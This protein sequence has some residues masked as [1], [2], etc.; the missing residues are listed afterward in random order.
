MAS[1][2]QSSSSSALGPLVTVLVPVYNGARFLIE[3]LESILAQTHRNLEIIVLDDASTDDTPQ[4]L[5]SYSDR[6]RTIRQRSNKGIYDNVNAGIRAAHGD[7]IAVYHA[8]DIYAPN[9]VQRE[10]AAFESHPEVGAVFCSDI[11][12]DEAGREYGRLQLPPEIR[13]SQPLSF[14]TVFNVLL[15]Y[16]NGFLRCP[17]AM[18]RADVHARVGLY[19]QDLFRN[20]SDL[21]MWIRIAAAHPI[22]VLDEHLY[23]YRH[24][25]GQSSKRYHHLRTKPENYFAIM[26]HHLEAGARGVATRRALRDYEAHRS[27]DWL[28]AAVA[29]Y[30]NGKI[31]DGGPALERVSVSALLASRRVQR[32]RLTLLTI[33]LRVLAPLPRF[34]SVAETF[35]RRWFPSTVQVSA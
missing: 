31:D 20:T 9:I 21:D 19:R 23:K 5:A 3:S 4:I 16:K 30:V 2:S 26:D 15:S 34:A 24:F 8:D 28:M 11:F 33:L 27:R 32:F 13:G 7:F 6:L 29:Q 18:V 10:L 1:T 14:P 12:V 17:G 22:L 25:A 35:R